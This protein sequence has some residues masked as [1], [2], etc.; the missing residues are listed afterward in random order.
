MYKSQ[1]KH[2]K[3][4]YSHAICIYYLQYVAVLDL[5]DKKIINRPIKMHISYI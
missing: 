5:Q 4:L 1:D 3:I 2:M